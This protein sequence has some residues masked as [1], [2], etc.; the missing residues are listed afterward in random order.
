MTEQ[1]DKPCAPA[2]ERNQQVIG[3]VLSMMVEDKAM[4]VLEMGSGTGQHAVYFSQRFPR[5]TWQTSDLEVQHDGILQWLAEA[6]LPNIKPPLAYEVGVHDWPEVRADLVFTANTLHIMPGERVAQWIEAL[7]RHLECGAMVM[8]YGPFKYHGDFT[9]ES[10]ADFDQ[11]LKDAHPERGIRDFEQV[12]QWFNQAGLKL[13]VDIS[14][15][16][17]NQILLYQKT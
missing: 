14:M 2:C 13:V 11:W 8:I 15:P 5:L 1:Q 3:D 17:N 16:A 4:T 7:G 6:S 12:D 10:N 9:S